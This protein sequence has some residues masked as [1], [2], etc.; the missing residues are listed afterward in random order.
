VE[1]IRKKGDCLEK[2]K[3]RKFSWVKA[4]AGTYGNETADRLAKEAA[5][6]VSMKHAFTKIPKTL[7][8]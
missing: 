2:R 1:E 3:W 7:S 5:R 8:I 4:H 6:S